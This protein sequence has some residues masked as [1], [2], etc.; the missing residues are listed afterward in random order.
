MD[1]GFM[2]TIGKRTTAG[3]KEKAEIEKVEMAKREKRAVS[4][5]KT[6][7]WLDLGSM[8]YREAFEIQEALHSDRLAGI[9]P[10]TLLFQENLRT[11]TLGRDAHR[12]NLLLSPE[13]YAARGYEVVAVS[14]GGDVSYHGP[15][16]LVISAIVAFEDYTASAVTFVRYL[17]QTVIDLLLSFGIEG[18]RIK[19]LSG[20]WVPSPATGELAKIAALGLEIDHGVCAHGLS[21]NVHPDMAGFGEII[22]CGIGDREVIDMTAFGATPSLAQVRDAFIAAFCGLFGL[23]AEALTGCYGNSNRT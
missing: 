16:Q 22:P 9:I 17:E 3:N 14:R 15:G 6:V 4:E 2:E 18:T 1:K 19:G 12:N 11:I 13:E 5:K 10:N 20:V 21:I 7:A 8:G 23:E